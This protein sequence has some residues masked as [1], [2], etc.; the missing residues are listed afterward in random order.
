M[1]KALC[2]MNFHNKKL[3]ED[4]LKMKKL[5]L[6]RNT[7]C[8]I[9]GRDNKKITVNDGVIILTGTKTVRKNTNQGLF[10]NVQVTDL[11][12]NTTKVVQR[13]PKSLVCK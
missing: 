8:E 2:D 10:A 4:I 9:Y 6:P 11:P 5:G 7:S 13:M 1:S 12:S 3:N